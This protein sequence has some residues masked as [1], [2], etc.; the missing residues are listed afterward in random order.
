MTILMTIQTGV[1]VPSWPHGSSLVFDPIDDPNGDPMPP[2][3]CDSAS[4]VATPASISSVAA[5]RP[6]LVLLVLVVI[7]VL[8][9]IGYGILIRASQTVSSTASEFTRCR[10]ELPHYVVV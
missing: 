2:P 9:F 4:V 10:N 7:V 3:P 6:R 1:Y 8:V 5:Q